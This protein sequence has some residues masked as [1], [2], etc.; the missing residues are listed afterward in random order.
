[1]TLLNNRFNLSGFGAKAIHS[2][3]ADPYAQRNMR[4]K[5]TMNR[6]AQADPLLRTLGR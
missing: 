5:S 3:Q 4:A 6:L 2:V 1:M